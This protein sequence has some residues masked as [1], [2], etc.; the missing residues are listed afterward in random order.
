MSSSSDG[1]RVLRG[2]AAEGLRLAPIDAE[3]EAITLEVTREA[4]RAAARSTEVVEDI[5]DVVE[6]MLD[7]TQEAGYEAGYFSGFSEGR[8]VGYSDGYQQGNDAAAAAAERASRERE[9]LLREALSALYAAAEAC[10]GRI[11]VTVE[12]VEETIVTAAV[13]LAEALLGRE[14]KVAEDIGRTALARALALAP[15]AQP[16]RAFLNPQDVETI[17]PLHEV[18]PGRTVEIIADP[19]VEPGGC[20]IEAG[21]SKVDA[22]LGPA[23]IRARRALDRLQPEAKGGS[24]S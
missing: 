1:P 22:Q 19:T 6:A 9:A 15:N 16:V 13:E 20:V 12:E 4:A 7:P 8:T 23:L 17:G 5:T 14:L 18:A 10:N 24:W 11:G 21:A 2:S 3:L